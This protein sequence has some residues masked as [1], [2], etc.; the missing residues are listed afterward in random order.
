MIPV[1]S[2]ITGYDAGKKKKQKED[3]SE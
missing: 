1:T 2:A 3:Q